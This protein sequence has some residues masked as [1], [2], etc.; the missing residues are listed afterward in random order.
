MQ[1][2][3]TQLSE[4]FSNKKI[5]KR[6]VPLVQ[7]FMKIV[8]KFYST[9]TTHDLRVDNKGDVIEEEKVTEI[10][11]INFNQ[12]LRIQSELLAEN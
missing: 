5:N 8:E 11:R 3:T 9:G 7:S 2:N 1:R 6:T 10:K 4:D 12:I